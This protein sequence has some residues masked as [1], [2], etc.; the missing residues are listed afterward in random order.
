MNT[1]INNKNLN[2]CLIMPSTFFECNDLIELFDERFIVFCRDIQSYNYCKSIN[3]KASFFLHDDSALFIQLNKLN[4]DLKYEDIQH[5]IIKRAFSQFINILNSSKV[6]N[7]GN[8]IRTDCEKTNINIYEGVK[9]DI[10][11][12]LYFNGDD[13][14]QAIANRSTE[15]MIFCIQQFEKIITNR[16][17]VAIISSLLNKETFIYD[18]NYGKVKSVY[19]YSLK[20]F[21]NSHFIECK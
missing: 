5:P 15:L 16:L 20:K 1:F 14:N 6:S 10:S 7:I 21:I 9:V 18:N 3:N 12:L 4:T 2:K 8:F 19:E 11:D 13:I 17:H